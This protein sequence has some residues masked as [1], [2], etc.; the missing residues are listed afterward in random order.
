MQKPRVYSALTALLLCTQQ[1]GRVGGAVWYGVVWCGR[2][3]NRNRKVAVDEGEAR[4]A[5]DQGK[6]CGCLALQKKNS[7]PVSANRPLDPC[8]YVCILPF[9][10]CFNN[11]R[12]RVRRLFVRCLPVQCDANGKTASWETVVKIPFIDERDVFG[13]VYITNQFPRSRQP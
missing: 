6:G 4:A 11:P 3:G 8:I 12:L 1:A 7:R 13:G 9:C 5:I 2:V 10:C